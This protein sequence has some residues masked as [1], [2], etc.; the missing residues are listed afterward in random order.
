MVADPASQMVTLTTRLEEG[1]GQEQGTPDLLQT[2]PT[3]QIGFH[4]RRLQVE[5][6]GKLCHFLL[7]ISEGMGF[8]AYLHCC[9]DL[10]K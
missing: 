4:R 1:W 2:T 5:K 9:T 3:L 8:P 6:T 10:P 7:L